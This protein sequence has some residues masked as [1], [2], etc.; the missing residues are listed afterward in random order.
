MDNLFTRY[1]KYKLI[2]LIIKAVT[3]V[4]G[5]SLILTEEHP[6]MSLLILSVGA[7]ANEA[8]SFIKEKEAKRIASRRSN[9][10]S[11]YGC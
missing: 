2:G 1:D 6:Y 10:E 9:H 11:E 8:V 5:G 7:A 3:G 4:V